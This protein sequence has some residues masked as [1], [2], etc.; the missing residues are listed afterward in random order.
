MGPDPTGFLTQTLTTIPSQNYNVSFWLAADPGTPNSFSATF[1]GVTMVTLTN[2]PAFGYTQYSFN[3]TATNT[4]SDLQFAFDNPPAYWYLD[5]VCVVAAV[6]S[7]T[8]IPTP[9][10]TPTPSPIPTPSPTPSPTPCANYT[11]TLGT[12]SFVPGTTDTG[13]HCD[14]CQ[15]PVTLPFPVTLYDQ[16][17]TTVNVGSNGDLIF[18]AFSEFF[19]VSCIPVS[20]ATYAI[21]P[22]WGDQLTSGTGGGIF[23]SVTGSCPNRIF[24]IEWRAYFFGDPSTSVS[25]NYEVRLYEGSTDFDVIFN[26][27][28]P[29]A[30]GA[31]DSAL[32]VGV[33]K[34]TGQFTLVGC[35][36][37]GGQ[38]PPVSA[39][40]RYH[41]TLGAGCPSPTPFCTSPTPTPTPTPSPCVL[42][43]LWYN[44][45]FNGVNGIANEQNT[46]VTQASVYD[47]FI[48]TGTGWIVTAVFSD[49]LASTTI[50]GANWEIRSG[51]S[52]GNGGTL[53]A[54]GTTAAPLVT[55][56]GRSGFGFTE[57]MVEVTGLN[58]NL[59]PGTYWLNVTPIGNGAGAS[60]DSQTS[61][62][63]AVG[64]P[65]GTTRT[66][67]R[68]APILPLISCPP[69]TPRLTNPATSPWA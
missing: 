56:T 21:G 16:S 8:P 22:Y 27:V 3:V 36:P 37:S 45:D 55:P 65:P 34:N 53:V 29:K 68:I 12:D 48:V 42:G 69:A 67:L 43:T 6:A 44:G 18:G 63:N 1:A 57:Y 35:D 13:N 39:G 19:G 41:F 10:P 31:N 49:N 60:F 33:Q 38:A 47:D 52:A 9:S 17:F 20:G 26:T 59:A 32:S 2:S 54:S 46:V 28:T 66:R 5:D 64:M 24:N 23:T 62:A 7:P 50:T 15:T 14:D 30:S 61:G 11:Y 25:Q 58:V 4:S 51:V 40:Q